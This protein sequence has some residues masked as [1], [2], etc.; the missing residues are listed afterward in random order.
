MSIMPKRGTCFHCGHDHGDGL[1]SPHLLSVLKANAD[2]VA[3]LETTIAKLRA[4]LAQKEAAAPGDLHAA[5][6]SMDR[7][8]PYAGDDACALWKQGYICAKTDA[9]ELARAALAQPVAV[10]APHIIE[11]L[12]YHANERD[13]LT[14]E[15]AVK[16]IR[17]GW[18]TVCGRSERAMVLQIAALLA[19]EPRPIDIDV[20]DGEAT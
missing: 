7:K 18:K 14:L 17:F 8:N 6:S 9:A 3:S 10:D 15:E 2:N 4:A 1:G 19:G 12:S 13:D 16:V 20:Q 11:A 5:I